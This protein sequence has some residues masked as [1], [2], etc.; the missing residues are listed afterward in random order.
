MRSRCQV[1]SEVILT[2]QQHLEHMERHYVST[3]KSFACRSCK[4][5]FNS[6][7]DLQSHLISDHAKRFFS[8][9]LCTEIY[10]T[11]VD[12]KVSCAIDQTVT[13]LITMLSS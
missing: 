10:Q 6:V 2:S 11:E 3:M 12:L 8:C 13:A 1:C 9:L 7:D 5:G 4:Q